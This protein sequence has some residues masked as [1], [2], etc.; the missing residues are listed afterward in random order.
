MSYIGILPVNIR[1]HPYLS[2]LAKVLYAEITASMGKDMSFTIG[3]TE[4]AEI[5]MVSPKVISLAI[6]ELAAREFLIV[7]MINV[8]QRIS[9]F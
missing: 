1:R 9:P 5:Y 2:P 6:S 8:N 4:L 7:R 3:N